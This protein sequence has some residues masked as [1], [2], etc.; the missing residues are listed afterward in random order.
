MCTSIDYLRDEEALCNQFSLC[1]QFN[2]VD[3]SNVFNKSISLSQPNPPIFT[4][5]VFTASLPLFL[6]THCGI[7][8]ALSA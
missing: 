5:Q 2:Q 6:L 4:S 8:L 1:A 3:F 7:H